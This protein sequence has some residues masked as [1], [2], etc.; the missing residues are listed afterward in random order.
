MFDLPSEYPEEPGL[1]DYYHYQQPHLLDETFQTEMPTFSA[2]DMSIYYDPDQPS[3]HK[4]PDWFAVLGAEPL[5]EGHL[6]KS[7]VLWQEKLRPFIIVELISYS[8]FEDDYG[9]DTPRSTDKLSKLHIYRDLIQ[10][11]YYIVFDGEEVRNT[12]AHHW[13]NG[14][15]RDI[16]C[17]FNDRVRLP[18]PEIGLELR[19]WVGTYRGQMY[20]WLRWYDSEGHIIPTDEEMRSEL[21]HGIEQKNK[22]IEQ[23]DK[24]I[25]QKDKT[26]EQ[27]DKEIDLLRDALRKAGDDPNR[28]MRD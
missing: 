14:S 5:F 21:S 16:P 17:V 3:R 11:P 24:T 27:K 6:R 10:V 1:P 22:V 4:R 15:F 25:E 2:G 23:K 7:Y 12:S 26:I 28:Y 18:I 19:S 8:T 13:E 20:C 9:L